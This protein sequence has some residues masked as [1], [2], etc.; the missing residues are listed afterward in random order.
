MGIGIIITGLIILGLGLLTPI[1][2]LFTMPFA[3]I[4]F[5]LGITRLSGNQQ[6]GSKQK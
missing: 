6:Y 4:L 3:V 2:D 1:N 5:I